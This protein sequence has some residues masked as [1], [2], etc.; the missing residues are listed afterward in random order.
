M[1]PTEAKAEIVNSSMI[2]REFGGKV[3]SFRAPN[4]DF[5]ASYVPFLRDA[6]FTLDSSQGSHKP[7]SFFK[8]VVM[9]D[10]VRRVPASMAPSL[11]RLPA[12]IREA[13]FKLMRDPVV[14][15]FHPWEFTD[16]TK[17][18]I[19]L[20]CRFQTG[21]PALDSLRS[22]IEWFRGRGATFYRM[23]DLPADAG[24]RAA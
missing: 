20:D 11:L 1:D 7:G 16:V 8:G 6:G 2:L 17:E 22:T 15:F 9:Q 24:R 19:P 23:S 13:A 4:L 10:K 21:Q 14:F 5:P 12:P 3:V 18:P